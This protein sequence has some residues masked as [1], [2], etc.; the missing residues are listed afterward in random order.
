[1]KFNVNEEAR[2]RLNK[3]RDETKPGNSEGV[4]RLTIAIAGHQGKDFTLIVGSQRQVVEVAA[5]RARYL[6]NSPTHFHSVLVRRSPLVRHS[7]PLGRE[8]V[9]VNRED[10]HLIES[11]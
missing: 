7:I 6:L 8:H 4:W 5:V 10:P 11:S 9:L 1:M 2:S 3:V